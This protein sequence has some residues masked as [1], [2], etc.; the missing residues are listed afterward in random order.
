MKTFLKTVVVVALS[1][2][3]AM[4]AASEAFDRFGQQ[5]TWHERA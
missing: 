1:A 3:A 2:L 5:G 4:Y